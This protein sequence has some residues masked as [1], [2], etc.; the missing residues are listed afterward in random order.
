MKTWKDL[1]REWE[2]YDKI[3]DGKY[4][5][6]GKWFHNLEF[7][8]GALFDKNGYVIFET[9]EEYKDC[10]YLQIKQDLHV[11]G[12]G[13]SDIP[14]YVNE[15]INY[16]PEIV[17]ENEIIREGKVS[18]IPVNKYERDPKARKKCIEHHGVDCFVCGM[19]FKRVYG[20]LGNG[21]IHIHHKV[22]ISEIGEEYEIDP[23]NDLIPLCPNCHSMIHVRRNQ[24]MDVEELK[25]ILL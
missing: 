4:R 13:I 8:P 5:E 11:I 17:Y 16:Y 2:I 19:N 24:I 25:K 12:N 15:S 7:F 18:I 21:F 20:K 10:K 22:P 23:I 1:A 3:K 6:N 9:E 14:G